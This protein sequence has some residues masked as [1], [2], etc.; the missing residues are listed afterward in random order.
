[1][2]AV[3]KLQADCG[4]SG[5]LYG[6][7]ISDTEKVKKLIENKTEV[8][9]GEV[10]G[11]HSEVFGALD[12]NEIILVSS[13]ENVVRMVE[14]LNMKV[15]FNPFDYLDDEEENNINS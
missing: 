11:K 6:L 3:F 13:D 8:Y 12:D 5:N 10:L 2:K 15:G 7:F 1:M 4:R 9:F 14:E